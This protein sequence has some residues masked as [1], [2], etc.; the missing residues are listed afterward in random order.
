[1]VRNCFS[2]ELG[3]VEVSRMRDVEVLL[4]GEL[5]VARLCQ[6]GDLAH[7][8]CAQ[9][10][11]GQQSSELVV[12]SVAIR[13]A[14]VGP[15]FRRRTHDNLHAGVGCVVLARTLLAV[16]VAEGVGVALH[17]LV[18]RDQLGE[19]CFPELLRALKIQALREG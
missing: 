9:F 6:G 7:I 4:T 14:M 18:V 3:H 5:V 10:Q 2:L 19:V 15:S 8:S 17:E 11:R 16:H 12:R 13:T 1:M